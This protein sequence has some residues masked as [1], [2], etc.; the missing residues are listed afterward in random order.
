MPRSAPKAP[1]PTLPRKQG[2]ELPHGPDNPP[3]L[4]GEGGDRRAAA[5]GWGLPAATR[6]DLAIRDDPSRGSTGFGLHFALW[7]GRTIRPADQR[8]LRDGEAGRL[9]IVACRCPGVPRPRLPRR[10]LR[11]RSDQAGMVLL[12]DFSPDLAD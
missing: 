2:R 4:A 10:R 5:G 9:A 12:V 1:T 6:N 3:S 7:S 8:G 11:S